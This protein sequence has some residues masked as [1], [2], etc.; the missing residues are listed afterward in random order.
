MSESTPQERPEAEA[1]ASAGPREGGG[2]GGE[3]GAPPPVA[4]ALARRQRSR[5]GLSLFVGV[6]A[7]VIA[8]WVVGGGYLLWQQIQQTRQEMQARADQDRRLREQAVAL[9]EQA[10]LLQEQARTLQ[11]SARALQG[12]VDSLS[13]RVEALQGRLA[14]LQALRARVD[15]LAEALAQLQALPQR[16]AAVEGALDQRLKALQEA[17]GQ[18]LQST[19]AALRQRVEGLEAALRQ[20][21]GA[22]R[23]GLQSQIQGVREQL[24]AE[25]AKRLQPVEQRQQALDAALAELRRGVERQVPS[26]AVQEA[27]YLVGLARARLEV[28]G[29]PATALRALKAAQERLRQARDPALAPVRA[30]LTQ[31]VVAL[32]AVRPVDTDALLGRLAKLAGAVEGLPVLEPRLPAEE[33][34]EQAAA[35]ASGETTGVQRFLEDLWAQLRELVVIRRDSEADTPLLPPASRAFLRQNLQLKLEEARL[36]LL[37]GDEALYREALEQARAWVARYFDT[38]HPQVRQALEELKALAAVRLRPQ[39]LP[40]L[41]PPLQ[42]LRDWLQMHGA[43]AAAALAPLAEE[44]QS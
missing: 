3:G 35:R 43:E 25:L 34:R 11:A 16:V 29:D 17:T 19:E 1:G 18:R 5:R 37:R 2:G 30:Q 38:S 12:K 15:Q 40:D 23:E 33:A 10:R 31:A 36:A 6:L 32:S 7:L 21:L 20:Q 41:G 26:W 39:G 8:G 9:Q 27:A 24:L 44:A 14:E 22:L 4:V 28:A 42:A 13:G